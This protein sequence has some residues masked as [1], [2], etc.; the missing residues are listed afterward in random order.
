MADVSHAFVGC[1]YFIPGE[2]DYQSFVRWMK[3]KSPSD[4]LNLLPDLLCTGNFY[5]TENTS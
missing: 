2:K 3:G 1:S 5:H 4:V